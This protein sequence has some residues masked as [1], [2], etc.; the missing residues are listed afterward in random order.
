MENKYTV[1][2]IS[3]TRVTTEKRE[4]VFAKKVRERMNNVSGISSSGARKSTDMQLNC[5]YLSEMP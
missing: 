5:Q 4:Y 3:M 1:N 2:E